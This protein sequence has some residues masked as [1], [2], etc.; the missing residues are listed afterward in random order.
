[1]PTKPKRPTVTEL[2]ARLAELETFKR[3]IARLLR[4]P[5]MPTLVIPLV[6]N[7][8]DAQRGWTAANEKL[9]AEN[10]LLREQLQS[11]A[12]RDMQRIGLMGIP[13]TEQAWR[14]ENPKDN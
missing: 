4:T 1:M 11:V 13:F 12:L 14:T 9:A 8:L 3:E 7:L 10:K 6:Q 5:D 2:R